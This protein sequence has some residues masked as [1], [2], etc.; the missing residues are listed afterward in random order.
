MSPRKADAGLVGRFVP[1]DGGFG[2]GSKILA[3]E[4]GVE[5]SDSIEVKLILVCA[6][7]LE[8]LR[9]FLA[10][11]KGPQFLFPDGDPLT[12]FL[13]RSVRVLESWTDVASVDAGDDGGIRILRNSSQSLGKNRLRGGRERRSSRFHSLMESA[14]ENGKDGK[15]ATWEK[16][17]PQGLKPDD[18][19]FDR[20]LSL[21]SA[22]FL[23]DRERTGGA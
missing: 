14:A 22:G 10:R 19:E 9:E 20:V 8:K 16:K 18:D 12:H 3:C 4:E 5:N 13:I 6:Q 21:E 15:G 11:G 7:V 23:A 2:F 1:L 17:I